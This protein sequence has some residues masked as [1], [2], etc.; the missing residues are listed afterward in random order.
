MLENI[1]D[2]LGLF[3]YLNNVYTNLVTQT[4]LLSTPKTLED[5]NEIRN[6][7]MDAAIREVKNV[8]TKINGSVYYH[9]LKIS[10]EDITHIENLLR[11]PKTALFDTHTDEKLHKAFRL[12]NE[13]LEHDNLEDMI[14]QLWNYDFWK[15]DHSKQDILRMAFVLLDNMTDEERELVA[16][17]DAQ[18]LLGPYVRQEKESDLQGNAFSTE[19]FDG[20]IK[21]KKKS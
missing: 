4:R 3:H 1:S 15:V 20:M 17:Y 19:V 9:L 16:D 10:D 11:G 7:K 8:I 5:S 13:H 6:E 18:Q 21:V 2:K 12:I 14:A